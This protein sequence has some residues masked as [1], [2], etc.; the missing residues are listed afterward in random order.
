MPTAWLTPEFQAALERRLDLRDQGVEY[1]N[2]STCAPPGHPRTQPDYTVIETEEG[3]SQF[4]D[5]T[6]D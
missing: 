6:F 5:F 2:L 1:Y 4:A 3:T